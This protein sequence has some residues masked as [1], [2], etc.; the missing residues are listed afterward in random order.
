MLTPTVTFLDGEWPLASAYGAAGV[1]VHGLY[2]GMDDVN[3]CIFKLDN[4][5]RRGHYQK[6]FKE[7]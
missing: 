4:S 1:L 6:L 5:G 7:I 3:R 2:T